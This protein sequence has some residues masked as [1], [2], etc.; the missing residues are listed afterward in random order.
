[1]SDS[2]DCNMITQRQSKT[3][4]EVDTFIRPNVMTKLRTSE[5][6]LE[7]S[8]NKNIRC[9]NSCDAVLH[10]CFVY[11]FMSLWSNCVAKTD[12]RLRVHGQF[13]KVSATDL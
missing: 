1:M 4:M 2:V 6:L 12:K 5:Q 9:S 8:E 13:G 7:I 3:K 11:T 10:L